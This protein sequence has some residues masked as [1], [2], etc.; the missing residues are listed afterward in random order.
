MTYDNDTQQKGALLWRG[1]AIL[2]VCCIF[3]FLLSG[4]GS[5]AVDRMMAAAEKGL[6]AAEKNDAMLADT[7]E[8]QIHA[9]LKL[10]GKA[11]DRDIDMVA[12]GQLK[13]SDGKEV[14]FDAEWVK[15]MRVG[16]ALALESKYKQLREL[17]RTR[18]KIQGNLDI[19]RDLVEQ[20]REVNLGY[21]NMFGRVR[22]LLDRSED[23]SQ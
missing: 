3:V 8:K 7:L 14:V 19:T 18:S 9:D 17:D 22:S 21:L 5:L 10:L 6:A 11:V 16:Y 13:E 23:T 15:Q 12:A 2:A 1:L 4:C 20:T